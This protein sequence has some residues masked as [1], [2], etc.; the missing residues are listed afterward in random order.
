[1]YSKTAQVRIFGSGFVQ[2]RLIMD[3]RSVP[4]TVLGLLPTATAEE[5]KRVYRKL[6]LRWHPDK[7]PGNLEEATEQFKKIQD[8]YDRIMNPAY[9]Q[10]DGEDSSSSSGSSVFRSSSAQSPACE[11]R[12]TSSAP[13]GKRLRSVATQDVD[14]DSSSSVR[15]APKSKGRPKSSPAAKHK[16]A[17]EKQNQRKRARQ[18]MKQQREAARANPV[19]TSASSSSR[20]IRPFEARRLGRVTQFMWSNP[21]TGS[22]VDVAHWEGPDADAYWASDENDSAGSVEHDSD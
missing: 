11:Q 18:A 13:F 14:T 8:A 7:N 15:P 10:E 6:A 21:R 12:D 5:V 4:Y 3:R 1:L 22:G 20:C 16:A 19:V 2:V 17:Q 9:H